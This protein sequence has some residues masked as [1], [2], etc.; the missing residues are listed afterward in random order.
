MRPLPGRSK[1]WPAP[2]LLASCLL[3][4]SC[5]ATP[6]PC[7]PPLVLPAV[8]AK[9]NLRFDV[10]EGRACLAAP[11]ARSLAVYLIEIQ[12]WVGKVRRAVHPD[13]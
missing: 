5:S 3:L 8:P 4:T 2:M 11:Q 9:P 13:K 12:A 10:R 6:K 1:P 7:P